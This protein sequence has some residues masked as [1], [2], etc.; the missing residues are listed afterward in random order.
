MP[1]LFFFLFLVLAVAS[2]AWAKDPNIS[3]P[4]AVQIDAGGSKDQGG[5]L[6][7][8]VDPANTAGVPI[9]EWIE[10]NFSKTVAVTKMTVVNGW[11]APGSFKQYGRIKT[12]ELA[13]LGGGK[14]TITLK[15]TDKPQAIALHAK[16]T[17]VRLTVTS[18]YHGTVSNDPYLSRISFDGYDPTEQQLTV[19]GR[20]EGCVRSRSSSSWGGQDDPFYYCARFRADDGTYYGCIDDLCFHSKDHVNVRLKVTGVIKPGNVLQVLEAVPVK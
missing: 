12:V 18:V 10:F 1:K 17:A 2:A 4:L 9:G 6:A 7:K 16:G 5:H 3:F 8:L 11:A 14:Q 20:Y 13:F 19:T 15:D